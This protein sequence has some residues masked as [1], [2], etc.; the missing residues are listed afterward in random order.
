MEAM[1]TRFQPVAIKFQELVAEGRI[2]KVVRVF[3]DLSI[4]FEVES[5]SHAQFLNNLICLSSPL[6]R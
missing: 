1:W 3:S 4:D 2:G 6:R 5:E